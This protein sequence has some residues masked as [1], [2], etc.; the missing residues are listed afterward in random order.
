[1]IKNIVFDMGNVLFAYNP[2]AYVQSIIDDEEVGN[3]ILKELF[4]AKEWVD[5]DNGLITEEQAMINIKNRT[6]QYK[7][8]LQHAMDHWHENLIPIDG[9]NDIIKTLKEKGYKIY[10]LSNTSMRF[11]EYYEEH[12]IF[13]LFDG[14]LI[15]AKEKLLKPDAAIFH[16]L[17]DLFS[18]KAEECI[19]IDDILENIKSAISVGFTGYHFDNP[20]S[21]LAYLKNENIL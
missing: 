15:S 14:L 5:L 9:M 17:L 13:D 11:Y 20:Q 16:R 18:L 10:L 2:K 21:F 12:P 7:N 4:Y 3:L 8:E 19:F 6:P 1:M